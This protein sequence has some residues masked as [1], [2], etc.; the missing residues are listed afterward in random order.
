MCP[1]TTIRQSWTTPITRC[2][3]SSATS[4]SVWSKP[5]PTEGPMVRSVEIDAALTYC[6]ENH[7][8]V[9]L[10]RKPNGDPPAAPVVQGGVGEGVVVIPPRE[11][12][13]KVRTLRR[14]PRATVCAFPDS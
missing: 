4:R 7:H 12:A 10:T 3:T 8:S 2:T 14:D 13:Y 11:P 6:R 1:R 5:C 9:L